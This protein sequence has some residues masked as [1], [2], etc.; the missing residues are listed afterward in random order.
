M[1]GCDKHSR[2]LL[3][4]SADVRA[5]SRRRIAAAPQQVSICPPR[6][7]RRLPLDQPPCAKGRLVFLHITKETTMPTT[8]ERPKAPN[9]HQPW[10][11]GKLIG[12]KPPFSR[13]TYG[14]SAHA[15]SLTGAFET[16]RSLT[17]RSTASYAPVMWYALTS[18]ML[19]P[20][21]T[22]STGRP[23]GRGKPVDR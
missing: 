1:P 20:T 3:I 2:P 23:S 13:G 16:W 4:G 12:P 9:P 19:L 6:P 15:Y 17:W 14:R 5:G 8:H 18:M 10:N 22:P 21:G 7:E 11:K